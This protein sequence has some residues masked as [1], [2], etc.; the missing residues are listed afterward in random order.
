MSESKRG[1]STGILPLGNRASL[2]R[3]T[4]SKPWSTSV[5]KKNQARKQC[6]FL[7]MTNHPEQRKHWAYQQESDQSERKRG[8][9][10]ALYPTRDEYRCNDIQQNV[11][12]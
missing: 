4:A 12:N 7:S 8:K 3:D 10:N 1:D 6:T 11:S 2:S 9:G 5:L